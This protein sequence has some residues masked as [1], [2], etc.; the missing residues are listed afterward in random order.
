[1]LFIRSQGGA[2]GAVAVA[3]LVLSAAP[4]APSWILGVELYGRSRKPWL[5]S[6]LRGTIRAQTVLRV[7]VIMLW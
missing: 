5:M 1:M 6:I 2:A 4:S 3:E 7:M